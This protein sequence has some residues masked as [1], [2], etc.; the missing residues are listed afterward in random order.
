MTGFAFSLVS[1]PLLTLVMPAGRAVP[2]LT[3]FGLAINS[4][5]LVSARPRTLP[6]GFPALLAAGAAGTIP[7]VMLL[8]SVPEE[9]VAIAV[10]L[11]VAVIAGAYLAGFRAGLSDGRAAVIPVGL[12]SGVMNGLMTF[13]GPPVIILLAERGAGRDEFRAGLAFYFLGLNLL[14]VPMLFMAGLLDGGVLADTLELLPATAAGA[15]LGSALAGRV[16]QSAFRR[17]VLVLLAVLGLSTAARAA[18]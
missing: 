9:P 6:S 10:G 11:A 16:P 1:L 15:V 7:G 14:T 3:L 12:L 13:S 2:M 4:I 5:V 17:A 18:F 8:G